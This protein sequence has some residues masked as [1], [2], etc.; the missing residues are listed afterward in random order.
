M[1]SGRLRLEYGPG[2]T[3]AVEVTPG[4][5]FHI[6]PHLVH[7]D[8]NPDKGRGLVVVNILVGEGPAVVNV[9]GP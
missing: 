2:G 7:R 8:L 4:D 5:F 6:P 9:E 1:V 3:E